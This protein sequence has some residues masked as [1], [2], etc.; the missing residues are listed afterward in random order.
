MTQTE[1]KTS[2]GTVTQWPPVAHIAAKK[3]GTVQEGD[4][5]LCGAKLMDI[6]LDDATKVC[7]E[8]ERIFREAI[9]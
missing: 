5:A 8:C 6:N 4:E 1:T 7:E 9:R 2:D 3:P